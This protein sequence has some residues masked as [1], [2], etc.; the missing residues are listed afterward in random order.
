MLQRADCNAPMR[1]PFT[2]KTVTGKTITGKTVTGRT[3]T[4]KTITGR[5]VEAPKDDGIG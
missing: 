4:G 5:I 3:F 2:G 1:E